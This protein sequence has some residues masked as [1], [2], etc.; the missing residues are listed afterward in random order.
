MYN[1]YNTLPTYLIFKDQ[2]H[3]HHF[4]I[5]HL[6]FVTHNLALNQLLK[7]VYLQSSSLS[8]P[9]YTGSIT[10][11]FHDLLFDLVT[12]LDYSTCSLIT[13]LVLDSRINHSLNVLLYFPQYYFDTSYVGVILHQAY[14]QKKKK[15]II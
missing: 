10:R 6:D 7:Q 11:F 4:A 9:Y 2:Y 14:L 13:N 12:I 1:Y 15:K 3:F 8:A 5:P